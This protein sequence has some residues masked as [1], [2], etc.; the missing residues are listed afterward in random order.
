M[1]ELPL[2]GPRLHAQRQLHADQGSANAGHRLDRVRLRS[3]PVGA[4]AGSP[5]AG[6]LSG[7][8]VRPAWIRAGAE[9]DHLP[10]CRARRHPAAIHNRAKAQAGQPGAAPNL[11]RGGGPSG[12]GG[13]RAH[14]CPTGAG[15]PRVTLSGGS[16]VDQR[17]H[18]GICAQLLQH[19]LRGQV[20]G[21]EGRARFLLRHP[22]HRH[23]HHAGPGGG[24]LSGHLSRQ[25]PVPL[26]AVAPVA[27]P[28]PTFD[29]KAAGEERAWGA[30]GPV[31]PDPGGRGV[32]R[33][34]ARG[35]EGRS[36][37]PDPRDHVRPIP[38]PRSWRRSSL[39]SRICS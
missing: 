5:A 12:A 10:L 33:L 4:S 38:R 26:G 14:A 27:D 8:R 24:G 28:G 29:P 36:G 17:D 21:G 2:A 3:G 34:R 13:P 9:R 19:R 25:G 18:P 22:R 39:V 23:P 1:P 20:A 37:C 31:R 35:G 7:G 32:S 16:G 6:W 15:C 30:S 11:G